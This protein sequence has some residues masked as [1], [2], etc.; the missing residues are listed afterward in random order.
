MKRSLNKAQM[1]TEYMVIVGLVLVVTIPLFYYAIRE[2]NTNIQINHANDAMS[3]FA[4]AADTVY[5]IG[6]GTQ[7]YV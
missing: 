5:S 6:P 7:K 1:A 2:S 3:T 4:K